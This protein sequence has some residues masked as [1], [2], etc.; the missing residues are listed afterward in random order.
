MFDINFFK[1]TFSLK[2]KITSKKLSTMDISDIEM[3]FEKIRSIKPYIYNIETTNYCNMKCVMCPRTMYMTRKNIWIDNDMFK[4]LIKKVKVH[5]QNNIEEF[6]N[7]LNKTTQY[8]NNEVSENGFYFSIVS[9]HLVLH[10]FGE[11]FLDKNLIE[12]IQI[13]TES[14]IPTYFSCTPAT[15]TVEKAK[16][17]LEAGLG[18][19][20]FSLDAMEEKKI[21][22]IRGNRANFQESIEKIME[23]IEFKKENKLKTLL[24]PCMI[25]MAEEESDIEMQKEFI[26]FWKGKDVY[27]YIKSQDNRWL[28]ESEENL[29]NNKSHYDNQYCEFPWTSVTIMA[30]GNVVPCTQISNNEL[31]LG[32]INENTL[33]EI[34]NSKKYKE[35]RKMHLTGNFPKGHKCSEKCDL[36][37]VHNYLN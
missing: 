21:K 37:K 17:A 10:G 25:D 20:K 36:K 23:L 24:V 34:W 6:W 19:L 18:V 31:V 22:A 4:G 1:K 32:N 11:P 26:D 28:Y 8:N 14:G 30:D 16:L 3:E 35:F 33:E 15:M 5:D 29:K 7:W 12:R 27:A 13:C 9:R 2:E